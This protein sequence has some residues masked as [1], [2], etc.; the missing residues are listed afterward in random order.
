MRNQQPRE[1]ELASFGSIL[2]ANWQMSFVMELPGSDD[3]EHIH[4]HCCIEGQMVGRYHG[5]ENPTSR[6]RIALI[7]DFLKH[8]LSTHTLN[9]SK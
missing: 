2:K 9:V 5:L 8:A 1:S 6:F 4:F 3:I 7:N